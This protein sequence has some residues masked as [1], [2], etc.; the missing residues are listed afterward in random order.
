VSKRTTSG[1]LDRRVTL[2]N[3]GPAVP[4]GDG[5]W[6][7]PWINLSPASVWASIVPATVRDLEKIAAGTVIATASHVVTLRYH[8]QVTTQTRI[9]YGTRTFDVTGVVNPDED[10]LETICLCAELLGQA[11]LVLEDSWIETTAWVEA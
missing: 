9:V 5:A 6:T 10:N 8:P 3:P 1:T 2:Q 11:P 7:H 4:D